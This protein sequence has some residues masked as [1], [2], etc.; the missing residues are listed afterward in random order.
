[1]GDAELARV[2]D[3]YFAVWYEGRDRKRASL[4]TTDKAVAAARLAEFNKRR[5]TEQFLSKPLTVQTCF[6]GY[7]KDRIEE[8]VVAIDRLEYAWKQLAPTFGA[9]HPDTITKQLVKDYMTERRKKV[10]DGTIH[11]ELGTLRQALR[12]AQ[13]EKWITVAPYVPM[14]EK[15][16]PKDHH[17]TKEQAMQLIAAATSP[18]LK[19]FII[20]ALST[21]GR[22][23]AILQLTWDRVDMERKLIDLKVP[24]RKATAKGRSVVPVNRMALAALQEAKAGAITGNVIE[25]GG[26]SVA[27][28]KTAIR[29]A[30]KRAGLY[31]TP[32]VLRHTAA[33]WM[34]EAD[35]SMAQIAQ[36]LGHKD[37]RTTERVYARFSPSYMQKAATALEL[38]AELVNLS[39]SA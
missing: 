32:H 39:L 21:A 36:Y 28:V 6:E 18:H 24:G 33:V 20:L 35:V 5:S 26:Q 17:L 27:S 16:A 14:P 7:L 3:R 30:A 2:N 4:G 13:R 11:V 25:W 34:A 29:T 8:G 38:D 1:M 15:P 12:F 19:L 10:K 23:Q 9:I 22:A 31:C 37:S